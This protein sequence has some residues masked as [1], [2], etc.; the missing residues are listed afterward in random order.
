M[1]VLGTSPFSSKTLF[2][3]LDLISIS[4]FMQSSHTFFGELD[5]IIFLPAL[6]FSFLIVPSA[7]FCHGEY[8]SVCFTWQSAC[9]AIFLNSPITCS[10]APSITRV[11]GTS[12]VQTRVT[13][14]HVH[15]FSLPLD[16]LCTMCSCGHKLGHISP[17]CE[18][19]PTSRVSVNKSTG[20]ILYLSIL[21]FELYG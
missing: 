18:T 4:N 10:L 14:P 15:H 3:V 19:I 9:L 11:L 13:M 21:S 2:A 8:G 1:T 6:F 12:L 20:N 7:A 16:I 17:L 5:L